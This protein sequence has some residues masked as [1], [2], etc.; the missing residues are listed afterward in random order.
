M[1]IER[2]KIRGRDN[3]TCRLCGDK[4]VDGETKFHVH[5]LDFD[6]Q[7]TNRYEKF[8]VMNKNVITLC[9]RCHTNLHK[10]VK[11]TVVKREGYIAKLDLE[12]QYK[13][14]YTTDQIA[15]ILQVSLK[16]V[17]RMIGSN[18][19]KYVKMGDGPKATIRVRRSDFDD[20]I[21]RHIC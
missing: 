8:D 2:E 3:F 16:T 20:F 1:E 13:D 18:V 21:E 9:P 19:F 7:K 10:I 14:F 4:W 12:I 17:Y 11:K 15:E 5:H 6:P